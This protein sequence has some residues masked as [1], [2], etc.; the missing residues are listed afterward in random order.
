MLIF[1]IT[2]LQVAPYGLKRVTRINNGFAQDIDIWSRVTRF[3][4]LEIKKV[5]KCTILTK[6]THTHRNP[7]ILSNL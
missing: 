7:N 2:N 1:I 3:D 5:D 6:H 4:S